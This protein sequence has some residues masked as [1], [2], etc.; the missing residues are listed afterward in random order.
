MKKA[1]THLKKDPILKP[2]LERVTVEPTTPS[3]D[4]YY[5]LLRAIVFQQL[6]GKA[7]TTIHNRFLNLF[8]DGYP[9]PE[10]LIEMDTKTLRSAGLS[11]QKSGYVQNIA[12]F[13][14]EEKLINKD[15]SHMS[16]DELVDYLVQIKGVGKWTVQMLLMFS[17]ERQDVLPLDDLVI[18]QSIQGMYGLE[19]TKR[20][21]K[22]QMTE[23]AEAWR[24]YRSVA[25]RYLWR[26]K[27]TVQ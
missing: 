16:D 27:D 24:P 19:G 10:L 11:G 8:D 22:K 4:L 15:L 21:L 23:I 9:H 13:F 1:I 7:A 17:M 12:N 25:C 14:I 3:D 5:N 6:S 2:L 18:F 26:W 20:E